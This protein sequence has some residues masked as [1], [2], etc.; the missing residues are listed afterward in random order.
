[1]CNKGTDGLILV[2]KASCFMA[3]KGGERDT[4]LEMLRQFGDEMSDKHGYWE[5]KDIHFLNY[6]GIISDEEMDFSG[7]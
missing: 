2:E 1:M 6:W 5:S 7:L 3:A 4:A